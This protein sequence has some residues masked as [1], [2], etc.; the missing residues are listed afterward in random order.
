MKG[1]YLWYFT[2]KEK[3]FFL[4]HCFH[5]VETMLFL[6]SPNKHEHY[7]IAVQYLP[8]EALVD[9]TFSSNQYNFGIKVVLI[10]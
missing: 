6:K 8:H 9:K 4:F 1:K 10:L 5:D 7:D 2:S 3:I